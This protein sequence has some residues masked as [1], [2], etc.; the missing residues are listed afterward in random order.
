MMAARRDPAQDVERAF[1][2][3][4]LLEDGNHR[5]GFQQNGHRRHYRQFSRSSSGLTVHTRS[6]IYT[7]ITEEKQSVSLLE[8][9]LAVGNQEDLDGPHYERGNITFPGCRESRRE[10]RRQVI[11]IKTAPDLIDL[12]VHETSE[13][14]DKES[15]DPTFQEDVDS[16]Y[17]SMSEHE[18]LSLL[19]CNNEEPEVFE[20]V[21]EE[22]PENSLLCD[23]CQKRHDYALRE[24]TASTKEL[25]VLDPN[26]WCCDFW[27]SVN[28]VPGRKSIPRIK[29]NLRTVVKTLFR[30]CLPLSQRPVGRYSTCSR[31]HPFLQRNLRLCKKTRGSFLNGQPRQQRRSSS[32]SAKSQRRRKAVN[33][34]PTKAKLKKPFMLSLDSSQDEE[35]GL[36]LSSDCKADHA[37]G[38]TGSLSAEDFSLTPM[39]HLSTSPN[40]PLLENNV[41][42]K[43]PSVGSAAPDVAAISRNTSVEES[44][45]SFCVEPLDSDTD[46]FDHGNSDTETPDPALYVHPGSFREMLAQLNSGSLR[47]S[48]TKE[49]GNAD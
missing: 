13:S 25:N 31:A 37:K 48:A 28:R 15:L 38:K 19:Q 44:P 16:Q 36:D 32:S 40:N 43:R 35:S 47:S 42:R 41:S 6:M 2:D 33:S 45:C 26:N 29:R 46:L 8:S 9:A 4:S 14:T 1:E 23:V 3:V 5:K 30:K 34:E 17:T 22:T 21:S 27:I 7:R 20:P 49:Y 18:S 10:W 39:R 11:E 12:D 24:K